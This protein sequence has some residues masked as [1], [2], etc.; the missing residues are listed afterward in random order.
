M[1]TNNYIS[2]AIDYEAQTETTRILS[3][4][5]CNNNRCYTQYEISEICS[6]SRPNLCRRIRQLEKDKLIIKSLNRVTCKISGRLVGGYTIP[7]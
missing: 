7:K 5:R 1:N 4:L 6:V 3:L 2:D